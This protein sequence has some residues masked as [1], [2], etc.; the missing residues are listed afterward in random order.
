MSP[1]DRLTAKIAYY[2]T[3]HWIVPFGFFSVHV[4]PLLLRVE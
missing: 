3:A 1:R 2:D 4:S